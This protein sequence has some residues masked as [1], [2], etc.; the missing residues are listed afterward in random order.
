ML[1]GTPLH[2]RNDFIEETEHPRFT[3][4][5]TEEPLRGAQLTVQVRVQ[6]APQGDTRVVIACLVAG[7]RCRRPFAEQY[8]CP[9]RVVQRPVEERAQT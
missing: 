3:N 8:A 6:G 1:R 7:L 4:E 2:N 5:G 9:V